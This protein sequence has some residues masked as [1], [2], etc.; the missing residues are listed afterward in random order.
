MPI[1]FSQDRRMRPVLRWMRSNSAD[2]YDYKCG[3]WN[4]TAMGEAAAAEF[5]LHEGPQYDIPEWVFELAFH[6]SETQQM[7]VTQEN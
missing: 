3:E 6:V 1:D 4:C 5:K 2:Y 7:E